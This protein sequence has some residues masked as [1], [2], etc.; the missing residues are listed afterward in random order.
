MNQVIVQPSAVQTFGATSA[1]L[2]TATAAA[3]AV[4]AGAVSAA[5]VA[6]FGL[7]GQE[8]AGAY[9]IAQANHLRAVGQ[10]AATHA[11]TAASAAAALASFTGA[12]STGA[13]GVQV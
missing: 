1:A 3:G 10:L 9:A 2:G 8:F 6:V 12:D 5:V 13:G 7:I 4:D 11:A